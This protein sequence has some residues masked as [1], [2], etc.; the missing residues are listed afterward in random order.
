MRQTK[1]AALE[2]AGWKVG[3]AEDFLDLSDDER[4]FIEVKLALATALRKRREKKKL[5]Q[6][7]VARIVG[8][9]QP[10]VALMEAGDKSVSVDLLLRSLFAL[11]ATPRELA[12]LLSS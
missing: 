12:K 8:S 5:T 7:D 6:A 4:K 1:R 2:K 9:S 3:S 10:R 11:G